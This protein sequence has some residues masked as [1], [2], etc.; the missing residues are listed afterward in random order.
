MN[1]K[2][3]NPFFYILTWL[4]WTINIVSICTEIRSKYPRYRHL[5]RLNVISSRSL[6]SIYLVVS[7]QYHV[8]NH[9]PSR[10]ST[11]MNHWAPT[12]YSF[13][14]IQFVSL[15]WFHCLSN[16]TEHK[17]GCKPFV[18]FIILLHWYDACIHPHNNQPVVA[19]CAYKQLVLKAKLTVKTT[20]LSKRAQ[21]R[22][23]VFVLVAF[24]LSIH[25]PQTSICIWAQHMIVAMVTGLKC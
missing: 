5:L 24:Y 2:Q 21:L 16:L 17:R 18:L 8:S 23:S 19:V 9:I 22:S 20:E 11:H 25:F 7:P 13:Y 3:N 15:F 1:K 12:C 6:W 14:N 4:I 10:S